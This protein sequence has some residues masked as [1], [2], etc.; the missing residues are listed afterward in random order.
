MLQQKLIKFYLLV[1]CVGQIL[2]NARSVLLVNAM[3]VRART[4]G[5]DMTASAKEAEYT[6]NS[7]MLASVSA[8]R[9]TQ[10]FKNLIEKRDRK[11]SSGKEDLDHV[12][13][14]EIQDPNE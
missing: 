6:Y 8:L 4:R 12:L 13:G 9:P 7:M 2:M 1:D 11:K 3:A 14:S 5:V 10:S